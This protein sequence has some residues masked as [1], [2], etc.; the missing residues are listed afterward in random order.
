[1]VEHGYW[2]TW[3]ARNS[4]EWGTVMPRALAVL[5][6]MANSNLE[7]EGE[8]RMS[9]SPNS[10]GRIS[11]F[12]Q[13]LAAQCRLRPDLDAHAS[14]RPHGFSCHHGDARRSEATVQSISLSHP[15]DGTGA[16]GKVEEEAG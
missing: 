10:I 13:Q 9:P 5:R 12:V 1:M 8:E 15:N 3:S 7:H 4:S 14:S 11:L 6:L 16:V 2:I